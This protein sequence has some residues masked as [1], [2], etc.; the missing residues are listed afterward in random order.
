MQDKVQEADLRKM[1]GTIWYTPYFLILNCQSRSNCFQHSAWFINWQV[2][3]YYGDNIMIFTEL[4]NFFL[5]INSF[6]LSLLFSILL[7]LFSDLSSRSSPIKFSVFLTSF[8]PPL[9]SHLFPH[10]QPMHVNLFL[11]VL[12]NLF[13]KRSF[14]PLSFHIN[15]GLPFSFYNLLLFSTLSSSDSVLSISLLPTIFTFS[16]FTLYVLQTH[17]SHVI[18]KVCINI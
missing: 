4:V 16:T 5:S 9:S 12:T 15:S 14:T 2:C 11:R 6:Y 8:I 1:G 17:S 10:D 3:I 13:F 7:P 18:V